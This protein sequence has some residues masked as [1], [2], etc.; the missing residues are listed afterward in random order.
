MDLNAQRDV[1]KELPSLLGASSE[2]KC[3]ALGNK[4]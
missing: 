1:T 2:E 3:S 4:Y